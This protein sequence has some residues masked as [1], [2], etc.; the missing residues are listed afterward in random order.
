MKKNILN[1]ILLGVCCLSLVGCDVNSWNDEYLDG[2]EGDKNPTEVQAIEYTLTD[3]DYA[4]LAANKTNKNLAGKDLAKDLANVGSKHY[5]TEAIPAKEYIPALLLDKNFPYFTLD[6]GSAIKL[7]YNVATN[8]PQKATDVANAEQYELTEE[9]YMAV[10][11]DE[12]NFI[13]AFAPSK[14]PGKNLPS[15][16]AE[17]FPEATAGQYV[18][19]NYDNATQEPVFGGVDPAPEFE[20]S[21]VLETV[22]EGMTCEIRGIITAVCGQGYI[23]TDNTGSILVYYG[24]D[25]VPADYEVGEQIIASGSV[26]SYNFGLQLT[27]ATVKEEKVGKQKVTY[28]TPVKYDGAAFD[29][30]LARDYAELAIFAQIDCD[31]TVS[32]DGRF[33]NFNVAGAANAV[34]SLYQGTDDQKALFADGGKYT[35][36]GYYISVSKSN[37]VPKYVNFVVTDAKPITKGMKGAVRAANIIVP[38]EN[39]NAVYTFDGTAWKVPYDVVILSAVDYSAMG[40]K[41]GNLSKPDNFLPTFLKV[42]L[43]YAKAG[44]TKYVA[45]KFYDGKATSYACDEYTFNG[46]EWVKNNGIIAETAQYVKKDGK[47]GIDPN[48]TVTLP[49]EK[50]NEI[51]QLYYQACVNYVYENIDKPLGSTGIKEGKFYVSKYGNNEY[52]S[53][54]SAHYGNVDIRAVKAKEQYPAGYEG[55]TDEEITAL[56]KHRFANEVMP[57]ALAALHPDANV[58]DGM[59]VIYTINFVAFDGAPSNETIRYK[60]IDKAKFEF[61]DCTWDATDK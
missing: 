38:T 7:T 60:V 51:S 9:D 50:G 4:T 11:G 8:L 20:L 32:P 58:V 31:V 29:A 53:G 33:Y 55:K 23:L 19:V 57:A 40:Q 34:G 13:E 59:D 24:R 54:T 46:T 25:F 47:W 39:E 36:T 43:P 61:V 5:F 18:I 35:V 2:F 27:G 41:F 28:P 52:Y 56:M 49:A 1:K 12:T 16:L 21:S 22:E 37:E 48:V 26:G 3:V 42:K 44:D 17:K 30:L 14:Q 15:L 10:W 45:Y 6:N